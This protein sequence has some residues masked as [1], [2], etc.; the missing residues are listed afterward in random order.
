[1]AFGAGVIAARRNGAAE[2]VDPRPY[3]VGAIQETFA[4]YP[5]MG[6]VL[7]AMGYSEQQITD[8]ESTINNTDCDLVVS[9]T[10]I[11]LAGL[12]KIDKPLVRVTYEY[13]DHGKPTLAALLEKRLAE[14]SSPAT[15]SPPEPK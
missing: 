14:K 15:D 11:D 1:M 13:R 7:P 5:H 12:V 6:A 8:L 2:L 4:K 10:P 9:A 3:L